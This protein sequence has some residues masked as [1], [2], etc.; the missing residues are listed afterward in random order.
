MTQFEKVLRDAGVTT[1][2]F[3]EE[4]PPE[5]QPPPAPLRGKMIVRRLMQT[6]TRRTVDD[7]GS[8]APQADG[9]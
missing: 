2:K 6:P 5:M 9:Q 7:P 1:V 4:K 3:P 8:N